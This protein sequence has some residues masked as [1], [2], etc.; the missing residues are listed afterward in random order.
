MIDDDD[1]DDD[2]DD[3]L[4]G[5]RWK[6]AGSEIVDWLWVEIGKGWMELFLK[7]SMRAVRGTRYWILKGGLESG[8]EFQDHVDIWVPET[9]KRLPQV[10]ST[11]VAHN[12]W[13]GIKIEK[14][15][16]NFR[17]MQ[18]ECNIYKKKLRGS[19]PG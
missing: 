12:N 16:P 9:L 14:N 4:A 19:R 8:R 1:D 7:A 18:V 5:I 13:D 17:L 15:T 3:C 2:D 10:R 6:I 11:D